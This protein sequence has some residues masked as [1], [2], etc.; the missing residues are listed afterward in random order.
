MLKGSISEFFNAVKADSSTKVSFDQKVKGEGAYKQRSDGNIE[1]C[2]LLNGG[3]IDGS[4]RFIFNKE[5][6]T[7]VNL[8]GKGDPDYQI[9]P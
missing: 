4:K 8:T 1:A 3:N 7:M 6:R 5:I 9:I 2:R